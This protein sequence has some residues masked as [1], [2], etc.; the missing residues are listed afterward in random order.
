[1]VFV[2]LAWAMEFTNALSRSEGLEECYEVSGCSTTM[3][4]WCERMTFVG[5]HC[6]GYRL[7]TEAEWEYAA[8]ASAP[9]L[10]LDEAGLSRIAWYLGN[11]DGELHPVA[12]LNPND[13][14]LYDMLGNAWEWTMDTYWPLPTTAAVDPITF[15]IGNRDFT[16]TL[17]GRSLVR[18]GS[19]NFGPDIVTATYRSVP[20]YGDEIGF[21]PVRTLAE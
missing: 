6:R 14:G 3:E 18:G 5:V 10:P 1:M 9:S 15:P 11:S 17:Q 19:I 20:G 4:E 21:R 13:W 12:Q 2:D 8:R 16:D 7:P